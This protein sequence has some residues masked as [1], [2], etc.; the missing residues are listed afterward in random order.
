MRKPITAQAARLLADNKALFNIHAIRAHLLSARKWM[1]LFRREYPEI[2]SANLNGL[3]G[4]L[5][6]LLTASNVGEYARHL[7]GTKG[8][9]GRAPKADPIEVRAVVAEKLKAGY[10]GHRKSAARSLG[11]STRRIRQIA[12]PKKMR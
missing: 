11:I 8:G 5:G 1:E 3:Q 7:R 4:E 10:R 2:I 6:W 9:Y 12:N